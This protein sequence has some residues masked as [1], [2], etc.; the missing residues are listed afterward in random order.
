MGFFTPAGNG[1]LK[2]AGDTAEKIVGTDQSRQSDAFNRT[3]GQLQ[4]HGQLNFLRG[5]YGVKPGALSPAAQA[6]Y[7]RDVENSG[8]QYSASLAAGQRSLAARGMGGAPTGA[9]SSIMNSAGRTR[10]L[11][12]LESYRQAQ[13]NTVGQGLAGIRGLQD[14]AQIY[15][16]LQSIYDPTRPLGVQVGAGQALDAEGTGLGHLGGFLGGLAGSAGAL[17]GGMGA[18]GFK[19]FSEGASTG[20]GALAGV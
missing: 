4:G 8:Q 16:G 18:M 5:L 15:S 11:N 12:D 19:P 14:N 17:M 2:N 1:I 10:D 9:A 7:Q 3:N 13:Q 20:S 6:A